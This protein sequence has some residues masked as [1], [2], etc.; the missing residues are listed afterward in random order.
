MSK[1]I[2]NRGFLIVLLFSLISQI[3]YLVAIAIGT[4]ITI[5]FLMIISGNLSWLIGLVE[6][7]LLF[8]WLYEVW[9]KMGVTYNLGIGLIILI[10]IRIFSKPIEKG[11]LSTSRF[12]D[13]NSR[14]IVLREG[15]LW[16]GT[17]T[18]I[19]SKSIKKETKIGPFWILSFE[20]LNDEDKSTKIIIKNK[21]EF[22]RALVSSNI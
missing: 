2:E 15:E 8:N 10:L 22:D 4:L 1:T 18:E 3:F 11:I 14:D 21:E 5:I 16:I 13:V 7:T 17:K 20:G 9:S 12:L 6:S 19:T